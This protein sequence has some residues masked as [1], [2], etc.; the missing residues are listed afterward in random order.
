MLNKQTL[1]IILFLSIVLLFAVHNPLKKEKPPELNVIIEEV[2]Q[3]PS[4]FNKSP[5]EGLFE[6]LQYYDVKHPNIV[7]AQAVLETGYFKSNLCK[8]KNNLFGL[9]NSKSKEFYAFDHWSESVIAYKDFLQ[10]R[11]IPP[12]DYYNF[13]DSIGYAEDPE[14]INKLKIIV[15]KN[16]KRRVK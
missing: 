10:Y 5:Q 6:A 7:Y 14:Y 2:E 16:D 12:N 15:N 13:L 8:E 1:Y 3:I 11:Y 9:Y 4:F